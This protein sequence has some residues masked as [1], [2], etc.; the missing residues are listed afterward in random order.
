MTLVILGTQD[1]EFTRLLKMVEDEIKKGLIK[2]EVIVQAGQ[3]KYKSNY[4]EILDLIPNTK[5]NKLIKESD[6]VIT[7]GGVGSIIS[8][9][10]HNKKVI[11]VPRLSKYGEHV[12]DHQLEIVEEFGRLG[13][14]KS[15]TNKRELTK[16]LE[17]I[18]SF[19]GTKYKSNNNKMIK[20]IEDFIDNI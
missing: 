1:K 14:I 11:A 2:G 8:A 12:N 3:T 17:E 18:D 4:M 5:F 10:K 7:H 19:E 20:L 16:A 6:L 13:Y 9:L 15:A